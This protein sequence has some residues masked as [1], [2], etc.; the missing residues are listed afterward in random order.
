MSS[1]PCCCESSALAAVSHLD[2]QQLLAAVG[3]LALPCVVQL[4][5]LGTVS[6]PCAAYPKQQT[7]LFTSAAVDCP[8]GPCVRQ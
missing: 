5:A 1:R 2:L 8:V 3:P 4:C 7:N 6:K